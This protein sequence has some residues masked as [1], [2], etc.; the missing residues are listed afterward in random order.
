MKLCAACGKPV[1]KMREC[2]AIPTC[3]ACLPPPP[4]LPYIGIKPRPAEGDFVRI[5]GEPQWGIGRVLGYQDAGTLKVRWTG[6][7]AQDYSV[8]IV[9]LAAIEIVDVVTAL[10]MLGEVTE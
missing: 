9:A 7:H 3:Y 10:G 6:V 2:F 5:P 1:E 8:W 4:P